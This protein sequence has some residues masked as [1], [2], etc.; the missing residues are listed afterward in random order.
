M[1]AVPEKKD[2]KMKK[3]EQKVNRKKEKNNII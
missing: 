2:E 1:A 3:Q